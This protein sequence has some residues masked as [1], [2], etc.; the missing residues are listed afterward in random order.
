MAYSIRPDKNR[1]LGGVGRKY[2]GNTVFC[3]QVEEAL[4]ILERTP[5]G[6]MRRIAKFPAGRYRYK[7]GRCRVIYE[8]DEP[9]KAVEIL[10]IDLRDEHTYD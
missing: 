4:A 1:L 5:R 2:S 6:Y 10:K 8:I 3:D 9:G 7:A